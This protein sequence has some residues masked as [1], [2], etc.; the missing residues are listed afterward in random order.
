VRQTLG[1]SVS[2]PLEVT[3]VSRIQEPGGYTRSQEDTKTI[4]FEYRKNRADTT[5]HERTRHCA[6]SGP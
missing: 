4:Q 6:G 5:G 3:A 2:A 1:K